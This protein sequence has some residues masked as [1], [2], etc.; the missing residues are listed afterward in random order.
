MRLWSLL[1][2]LVCLPTLI[3]SEDYSDVTVIVRG[4]KTIAATSDE[5]FALPLIGGLRRSA[6]MISAHGERLLS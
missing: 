5:L 3:V 2:L 4:S 6:T 1:L